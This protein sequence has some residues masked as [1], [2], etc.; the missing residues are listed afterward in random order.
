MIKPYSFKRLIAGFLAAS[1]AATNIIAM[2]ASA[3]EADGKSV[4]FWPTVINADPRPELE[5]P[6]EEEPEIPDNQIVRVSIVLEKESTI[7]AGYEISTLAVDPQAIAYREDLKS[8]QETVEEKIEAQVL[9]GDQL[10]V[11]WN[12]TLAA[13]IISANVEYGQ[14][15]EIRNV[16]GVKDVVIEMQYAPDTA[17]SADQPN[18]STSSEMIGSSVAYAGGYTGAGSRVAIIDTGVDRDHQSFDAG[19][20]EYSL[21][22]REDYSQISKL[23]LTEAEI[24]EVLTQLNIFK[25]EDYGVEDASGLYVSSKIPFAYNYVDNDYDITHDND[26]QEEHGSHVTGIAAANAYIPDGDGGY[27]PA[28]ISVLTQGVAPDAQIITMKVFGKNGGAYDSD[29]MA[30]IEDAI[31]LGADSINLSL[32]S[33]TA[34]FGHSDVYGEIMDKLAES[35]SVVTMSMGNSGYYAES[36]YIPTGLPYSDDVN[37]ATGGSPA[38]YTNSLAVASV[39]NI[40]FT[41]DYLEVDGELIFYNQS[42]GPG[43]GIQTFSEFAGE[44]LDYVFLDAYAKEGDFDGI[45]VKGKVAI[46][47]RGEG[48]N[49]T[50]KGNRAAQAGAKAVIVANN[51]PGAAISMVTEGY[52]GKIPYVSITKSD[53]LILLNAADS[54]DTSDK[55]IDYYTG[56][57]TVGSEAASYVE[58]NGYYTMSSFSSWGV[59]GTLELK[60]EITAPGG[61]IYSVNGLPKDTDKYENMSGTSMAAPQVA[62]MAAVL[63]QYIR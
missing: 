22:Q 11:V 19:A 34:G 3:S 9:D 51:V 42:Y 5:R 32:G 46:V 61:N 59:P 8:E 47:W 58:Y 56:S 36:S 23:L 21:R 52:T 15:E 2:P 13:N 10:D 57:L 40:G 62:G 41:G 31:I 12:L 35:A 25:K 60:P 30:A 54:A 20:F 17:V 55:G 4:D 37:F 28:L 7:D 38:T 50:D 48:V 53:A 33:T 14:I 45:D 39:D 6:G 1:V 18:M 24:E 27:I 43:Q 49:F 29:Y 44:T 16:K 26:D 63:A